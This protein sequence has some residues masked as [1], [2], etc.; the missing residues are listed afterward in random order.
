[1][2]GNAWEVAGRI[3]YETMLE[4][5]SDSQF[6]GCARAS[7]KIASDS[8]FGPKAKKAVQAAWKEVG[9]KV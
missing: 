8:R 4:L 6:V 9:V 5:A 3:W 2:G 7:I 1:M